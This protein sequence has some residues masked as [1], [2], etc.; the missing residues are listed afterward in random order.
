[1]RGNVDTRLAKLERGEADAAVLAAAGLK[2][3][4][5]EH[6]V[7]EYFDPVAQP[8]APAQGALA[9]QTREADVEAP[10]VQA[11]RC[12]DT[13]IAVAAERGALVALE[14]SCRTAIGAHGRLDG[15][16]LRLVVE[17]LAPDG[18]ERWRR[19]HAHD[20]AAEPDPEST[21]AA[22]GLRLGHE[23]RDAAGDRL[24]L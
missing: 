1:M 15:G 20:L 23:I 12:R 2:R 7:R 13:G 18:S 10:W 24:V 21:A 6:F 8:P 14:G 9:I 22:L 16:V 19:E 11:L 4:G 17:A 5:L 3:L